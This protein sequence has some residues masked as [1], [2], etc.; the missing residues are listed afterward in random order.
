MSL[1]LSRGLNDQM[2]GS[3]HFGVFG[4]LWSSLG[5]LYAFLANRAA[6]RDVLGLVGPETGCTALG[7]SSESTEVGSADD[8]P[9][10]LPDVD[11]AQHPES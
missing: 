8:M 4:R 1:E 7:A 3:L 10:E 9:D 6:R 11:D 2:Q 5:S